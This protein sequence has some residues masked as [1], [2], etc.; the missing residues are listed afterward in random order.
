MRWGRLECGCSEI[1]FGRG[2]GVGL[3]W[4]GLEEGGRGGVR[5]GEREVGLW[6]WAVCVGWVSGQWEWAG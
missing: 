6:E 4:V 3:R 5:S 2:H 1:V